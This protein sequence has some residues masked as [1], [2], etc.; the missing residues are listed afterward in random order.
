VQNQIKILAQDSDSDIR[1]ILKVILEDAHFNVLTIAN[2][3]QICEI[4]SS[5]QPQVVLIDVVLSGKPS[6]EACK[7]VKSQFQDLPIVAFSC[8]ADIHETFEVSGFDDYIEKPF[9][10]NHLCDVLS[11]NSKQ[12]DTDDSLNC[13]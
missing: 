12:I 3:D 2:C 10:I 7:R 5:F 6:I 8:N 1:Y 11:R 13:R 4:V 9:D